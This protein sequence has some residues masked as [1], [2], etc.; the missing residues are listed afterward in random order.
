MKEKGL[1][2]L[3]ERS[4]N[5]RHGPTLKFNALSSFDFFFHFLFFLSFFIKTS[6]FNGKALSFCILSS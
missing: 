1:D 3:S 2:I 5:Q 6:E 4:K